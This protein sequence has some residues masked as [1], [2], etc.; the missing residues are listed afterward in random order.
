MAKQVDEN[1]GR[2][3]RYSYIDQFVA[4][5][6]GDQQ[7]SRLFEQIVDYQSPAA[8]FVF[9]FVQLKRTEREKGGLA[10]GKKGRED[11]KYG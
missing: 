1:R 11:E 3:N 4:D 7:F 2:Y 10:S 9:E 5:V 6:N 8:F